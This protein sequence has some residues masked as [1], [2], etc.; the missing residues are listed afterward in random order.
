MFV[1]PL[2]PRPLELAQVLRQNEGVGEEVEVFLSVATLQPRQVA[3]QPVFAPNLECTR[4]VIHLQSVE[5]RVIEK[6][7]QICNVHTLFQHN[8]K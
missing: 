2:I 5:E 1:S 6:E 4:E 7:M 3:V 8:K